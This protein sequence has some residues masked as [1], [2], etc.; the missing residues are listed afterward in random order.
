MTRLPIVDFA[1]MEKILI[2][3]GFRAVK[4]KGSH[5]F[6][7]H[8]DGRTTTIPNHPGRDL[9]RPLRGKICYNLPVILTRNIYA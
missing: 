2:S 1:T 4:Q 6:Y 7:R 9:A 5:V 8:P 3:L